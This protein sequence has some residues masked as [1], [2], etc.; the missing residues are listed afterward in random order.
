MQLHCKEQLLKLCFYNNSSKMLTEASVNF[1]AAVS[2][3]L[4]IQ[5]LCF[6]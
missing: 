6:A 2:L 1:K 4:A 3:K 5:G